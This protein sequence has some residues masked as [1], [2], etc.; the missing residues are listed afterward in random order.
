MVAFRCSPLMST[1]SF[2]L[3]YMLRSCQWHSKRVNKL[4]NE[5]RWVSGS[6]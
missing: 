2:N 4:A 6:A 3:G 1:R 5:W